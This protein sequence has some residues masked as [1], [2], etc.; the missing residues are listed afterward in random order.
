[1]VIAGI[2]LFA[3]ASAIAI[4]YL[5]KYHS[6]ALPSKRGVMP[7][8][9]CSKVLSRLSVSAHSR[10]ACIS[11][12]TGISDARTHAFHIVF[13]LLMREKFSISFFGRCSCMSHAHMIAVVMHR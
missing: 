12:G 13:A 6:S 10:L 11:S 8:F 7:L 9:C 3:A 2:A 1:M 5:R 4:V